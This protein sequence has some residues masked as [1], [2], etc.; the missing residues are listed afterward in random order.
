VPKSSGREK[1]SLLIGLE[2]LTEGIAFDT[3]DLK[4]H[5]FS[6]SLVTKV[7][8]SLRQGGVLERV[9]LRKYLFADSFSRILKE[10]VLRKTPR[11]GLL[12]FPTMAVFDM[13][14]IETWTEHD[15]DDFVRRLKQHWEAARGSSMKH[16]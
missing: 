15:L 10:D 9:N 2:V 4:K 8:G 3:N 14:G 16:A 7:L 11:S 5:G 1:L 12:Q 6:H 13:C